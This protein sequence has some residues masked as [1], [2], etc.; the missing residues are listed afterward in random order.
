MLSVRITAATP[1]ADLEA[2]V[3]PGVS[4]VY[5]P[6]VESR[7]QIEEADTL[8]TRL[9][10]LRGIRPGTVEVRPLIES[11]KGVTMAHEIASA[12][13]RVTVC[14]IGPNINLELDR[15]GLTYARAECELHARA[16]ELTPLDTQYVLD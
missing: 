15:D 7:R 2:A 8:I 4:V 5:Y 13:P 3:R 12:S 16:L 1:E 10:K 14:G 6:R 9:E 11:P